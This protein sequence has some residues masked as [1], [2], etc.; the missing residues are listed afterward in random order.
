MIARSKDRTQ[1]DNT[2]Q[3]TTNALI[4][5]KRWL[6]SPRRRQQQTSYC[7]SASTLILH[8]QQL[9]I[10]IHSNFRIGQVA[11]ADERPINPDRPGGTGNTAL[12]LA[13]ISDMIYLVGRSPCPDR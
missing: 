8:L 2:T 9:I 3:G 12:F 5:C 6:K 7:W 10:Q 1:A 4:T 11:P 13:K